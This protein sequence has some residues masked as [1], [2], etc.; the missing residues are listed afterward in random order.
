M[1]H[2]RSHPVEYNIKNFLPAA[3]PRMISCNPKSL[4]HSSDKYLTGNLQSRSK[5]LSVLSRAA[6]TIVEIGLAS[7]CLAGTA[8]HCYRFPV[9][10]VLDFFG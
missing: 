10:L 9:V 1:K 8:L 7:S 3:F 4:D 6:L 5:C 2:G